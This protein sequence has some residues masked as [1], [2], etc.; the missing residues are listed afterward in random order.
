[1]E[2]LKGS[3]QL[4]AIV[5]RLGKLTQH[6]D[7]RVR[8]DACYYLALSGSPQASQYIKPLLDDADAS[9]REIAQESLE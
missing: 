2:E 4:T 5:D 1:M 9:V 3:T 6:E 7:A 8:G